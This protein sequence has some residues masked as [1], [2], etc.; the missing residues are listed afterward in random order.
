MVS[1][2][3]CGMAGVRETF[4]SLRF[5]TFVRFPVELGVVWQQWE[6][7]TVFAPRRRGP[8]PHRR[9]PGSHVAAERASSIFIF[10][11]HAVCPRREADELGSW[12][13]KVARSSFHATAPA[14]EPHASLRG[15]WWRICGA[16][17]CQLAREFILPAHDVCVHGW[18]RAYSRG[19]FQL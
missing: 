4:P 13:T 9:E 19:L 7:W 12:Q 17:R 3:L 14:A 16:A 10:L 18:C 5:Q 1:E 11:S 15:C 2:S 8:S 6:G